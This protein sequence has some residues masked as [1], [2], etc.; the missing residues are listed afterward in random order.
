ML[1]QELRERC[2]QLMLLLADQVQNLPLGNESW[3][4]TEREL[5]AAERALARLPLADG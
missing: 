5:L 2:E 4:S 1:R 3:M